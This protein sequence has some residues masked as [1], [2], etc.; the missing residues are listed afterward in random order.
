VYRRLERVLLRML[1]KGPDERYQSAR[2]FLEALILVQEKVQAGLDDRVTVVEPRA[3]A[4]EDAASGEG[5][6]SL[7]Q[8]RD[9]ALER[10]RADTDFYGPRFSG[11]KLAWEVVSAEEAEDGYQIRLSYGPARRFPWSRGAPGIEQFDI[12]RVGTTEFRRIV[13]EPVQ[14]RALAIPALVI[15]APIVAALVAGGLLASRGEGEEPQPAPVSRPPASAP[16]VPVRIAVVPDEPVKLVTPLE[17]VT[18]EL[19]SGSVDED[20]NLSYVPLTPQ[21]IPPLPSGFVASEVV[22]DLSVTG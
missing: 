15:G 8:A 11:R 9:F 12:D 21:E 10:A 5:P 7:E 3:A 22:F 20:V 4:P 1:A 14:K 6:I 2:E 16:R 17:E 13:T 18:V 19:E